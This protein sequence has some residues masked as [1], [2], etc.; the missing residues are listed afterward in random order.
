MSLRFAQRQ[1]YSIHADEYSECSSFYKISFI[2]KK[3][4][5]DD[6]HIHRQLLSFSNVEFVFMFG[7]VNRKI[8]IFKENHFLKFENIKNKMLR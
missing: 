7:P 4:K 6:F 2:R 8:S 3:M 5:F 1:P